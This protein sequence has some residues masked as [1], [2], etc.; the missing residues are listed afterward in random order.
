MARIGIFGGTFD[1]PHF[2][3]LIGAEFAMDACSL[4]R[5]LFIPAYR[6][7]HKIERALSKP[8]D[9]IAMLRLAIAGN[10]KFEL[11]P[12]ELEREGKSYT[13]ETLRALKYLWPLDTLML[14]IGRDQFDSFDTWREPDEILKLAE[15]TVLARTSDATHVERAY[16]ATRFDSYVTFYNMPLIDISSTEIRRRIHDGKSIRY[17]TPD[18]VLAYIEE[19]GLYR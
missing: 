9:R 15:I 12:I 1:P 3:H 2:G 4:D 17:Q 6:P 8:S 7:P 5:M 16:R 11:S 18:A 19:H 10:Q 14:I 13:V